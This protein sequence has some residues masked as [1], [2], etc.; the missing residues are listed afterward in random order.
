ML[1]AALDRLQLGGDEC[2]M[3]S[4]RL[5]T[6]IRMAIDADM[7]SVLVLTGD[8]SLEMIEQHPEEEHPTGVIER[9]HEVLPHEQWERLGWTARG[10]VREP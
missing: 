5:V 6:D 2:I 7:P 3:I 1:E 10:C 8:T 9:A 4:A